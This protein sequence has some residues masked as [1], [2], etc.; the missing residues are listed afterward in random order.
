MDLYLL[1]NKKELENESNFLIEESPNWCSTMSLMNRGVTTLQFN[2]MYGKL[3]H[4][5]GYTYKT[6]WVKK[7]MVCEE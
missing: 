5:D 4:E 2:I 7:L 1:N 6:N 3:F